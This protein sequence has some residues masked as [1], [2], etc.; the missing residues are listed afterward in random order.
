M[1]ETTAKQSGRGERGLY[2]VGKTWHIR[3]QTPYGLKRESTGSKSKEFAR[4]VLAA[5]REAVASG[6]YGLSDMRTRKRIKFDEMA[7]A[8]FAKHASVN[9]R[10]SS[11]TR[12]EGSF[13][14]LAR[15]FSGRLIASITAND[16]EQYK[17]NRAS[18]KV[19]GKRPAPGTVNRELTALKTA[20][21]LVRRGVLFDEAE[22]EIDIPNPV[23]KVKFLREDNTRKEFFTKDEVGRLMAACE[24]DS[25]ELGRVVFALL[26]T[27]CRAGE[28]VSLRWPNVNLDTRQIEITATN[29]KTHRV[30]FIPIP[31][32]LFD[33]LVELRRTGDPGGHVYMTPEGNQWNH[34]RLFRAFRRA[35]IEAGI[36]GDWR[37]AGRPRPNLHVIRH[38]FA[39]WLCMESRDLRLV[40]SLLGHRNQSTTERYAHLSDGYQSS[41]AQQAINAIFE[42]YCTP[43]A[44]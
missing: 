37:A 9:K 14:N 25:P 30:R 5:R 17:Q 24:K 12:D 43:T 42:N 26:A 6:K 23:C 36:D 22:Y 15:V 35:A 38:T 34:S 21:N 27:G 16:L 3:Y 39:S 28:I 33:I 44:Q 10:A 31:Q 2:Q 7:E 41:R 29:S 19:N 11:A 8:Y 18:G 13:K 20:F 4:R 32:Q 40:S 1:T